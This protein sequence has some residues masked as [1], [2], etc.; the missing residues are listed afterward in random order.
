MTAAVLICLT[1]DDLEVLSAQ[2]FV[3]FWLACHACPGTWL[4]PTWLV[5]IWLVR[6][7]ET[8]SKSSL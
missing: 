3:Q 8:I 7:S 2:R 6:C 1:L 5:A 4:L